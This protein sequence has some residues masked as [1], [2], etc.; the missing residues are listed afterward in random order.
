VPRSRAAALTAAARLDRVSKRFGTVTALD[1]VSITTESGDVLALLGPNGAGKSTA[2]AVLLGLRRPDEGAALLFGDDPRRPRAR[3]A[4]G[5]ALQESAYP[6]T[7]RVHELVDL[8]RAHYDEPCERAALLE[9]FGLEAQSSRQLGGLSG[10][11]RR[12]VAVALAFAG[13]PRLLVL[14][15]PTAGLDP[16]A[17]RAVW[18]AV[19]AHGA[20]GGTTLLTTHYLEEAEALAT[21][22]VLID[23]GSIVTEGTV[24]SIKKAA[25][26]TR[27]T[28]KAPPGV[29]VDGA[30]RDGPQLRILTPDAGRTVEQ[31]VRARIAL[32]DLEVRPLTLEEAIAAH[33]TAP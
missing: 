20:D 2:L 14:D 22:I 24:S 17:R 32:V 31:L 10:G 23:G 5:V 1:R 19:R 30:A 15:E 8:A 26:L 28:F 12:R 21:R 11:E 25:G 18:A 16:P 27:V 29:V 4:I 3:R 9:R 33:R 6:A 13:R 7:L